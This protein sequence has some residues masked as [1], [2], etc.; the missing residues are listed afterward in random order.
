MKDH[1]P[2]HKRT[3]LTRRFRDNRRQIILAI[4]LPIWVLIGFYVAQQL[5]VE[6]VRAGLGLGLFS[7]NPATSALFNTVLAAAVYSLSAGIVIGVPILLKKS[8]TSLRDL[9]LDRAPNW[10]DL[11]LAPAGYVIYLVLSTQLIQ[12]AILLIP[13]FDPVQV[14]E[15]GFR[16]LSH[17][18]ELALAF[19]TLVVIAPVAEEIL[20]RGYLYGKLRRI[21]PIAIAV[22][23]TSVLFGFLHGQWNVAIDV[24]AL[25]L[26][27]TS[28]REVTGSIWVSILLHMLKNGIAFYVLFINPSI[29]N[30]IGM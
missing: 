10:F 5:V 6:I 20:M 8:R 7:T 22:I 15:V 9:G 11:L 1:R 28:L 3:T 30:T 18:Y 23:I 17:N 2:A 29:L 4:W 13:G 24:F 21:V 25:S 27:L 16:Y 14:Q 12:A 19:L 26:V